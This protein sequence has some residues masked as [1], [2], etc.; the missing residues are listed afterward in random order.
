MAGAIK[1]FAHVFQVL[2]GGG[3]KGAGGRVGGWGGGGNKNVIHIASM[4]IALVFAVFSPLCTTH[5]AKAVEQD[6]LSQTSMPFATMPKTLVSY[7]FVRLRTT[8][9]ARMWNKESCHKRACLWPLCQSIG[10]YS[11]F[12]CRGLAGCELRVNTLNLENRNTM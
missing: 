2:F 10:I 5:C 8:Y 3:E 11:V 4:S 7:V 6:K 9:C 12:V 1:P